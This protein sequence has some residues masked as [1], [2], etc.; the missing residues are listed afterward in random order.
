MLIVETRSEKE[1]LNLGVITGK[2]I[3]YPAIIALT[4]DLGSGKTVFVK[5][6]AKGMG[7]K[8]TVKSPSF[9]IINEYSAPHPLYHFDLYRINDPAELS[10][11]GYEE[12]IS[13]Q[14]GV[15]AIEWADKIT[16]FLPSEY[17]KVR[18]EIRDFHLRS[19]AFIPEGNKNYHNLVFKIKSKLK[20]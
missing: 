15:V 9:V 6:I 5:G 11:L 4:G 16:N 7:I 12:Y 19:I 18:I 17:L 13:T 2:N 3:F 8:E 1:T 14:N 20:C 10:N